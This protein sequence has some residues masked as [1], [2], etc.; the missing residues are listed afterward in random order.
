MGAHGF[1]PRGA[2]EKPKRTSGKF[3]GNRHFEAVANLLTN[4]KTLSPKRSKNYPK[5]NGFI[6]ILAPAVGIEPT[7]N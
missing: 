6:E 7:T 5:K 4:K 1:W 3:C 2:A